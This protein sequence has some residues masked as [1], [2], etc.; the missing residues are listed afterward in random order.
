[1][2]S[3]LLLATTG[4]LYHLAQT[5]PRWVRWYKNIS[6]LLRNRTVAP[7]LSRPGRSANWCP[8]TTPLGAEPVFA[9]EAAVDFYIL[10]GRARI[11][12]KVTDVEPEEGKS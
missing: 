6:L 9:A 3:L 12:P 1:M 10:P 5:V 11:T 7:E 8:T 4:C 2:D